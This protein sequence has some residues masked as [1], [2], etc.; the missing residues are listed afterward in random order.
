M[1]S[2]AFLKRKTISARGSMN[3]T[4]PVMVDRR[5]KKI[6]FIAFIF[7]TSNPILGMLAK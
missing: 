5:N 4:P 6:D 2:C 1:I 7:L 3:N